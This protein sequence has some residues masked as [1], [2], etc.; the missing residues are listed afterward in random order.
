MDDCDHTLQNQATWYTN[1]ITYLQLNKFLCFQTFRLDTRK[2]SRRPHALLGLKAE[3]TGKCM[4]SGG[5]KRSFSIRRE[6]K[7]GL[8]RNHG[9]NWISCILLPKE[10]PRSLHMLHFAP[11]QDSCMWGLCENLERLSWSFLFCFCDRSSHVLRQRGIC[12]HMLLAD[13]PGLVP[14]LAPQNNK[15]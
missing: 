7:Q 3:I 1:S 8:R 12:H 15:A 14:N 4:A 11:K 9:S 5:S 6:W 2:I 13:R 10:F